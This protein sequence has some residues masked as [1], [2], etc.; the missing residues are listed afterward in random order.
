[1]NSVRINISLPKEVFKEVS[2]A[3]GPRKRSQ[4]ITAAIRKSLREQ[5]AQKLAAEYEEAS[6]EVRR[7]NQELEGVISDGLDFQGLTLLLSYGPRRHGISESLQFL[8]P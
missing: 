7:I 2:K 6:K 3:V 8:E 4:F 5:K 1:M